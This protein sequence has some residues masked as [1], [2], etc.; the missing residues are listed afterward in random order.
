MDYK[1]YHRFAAKL[2]AYRQAFWKFNAQ[3]QPDKC[4]AILP[5][6]KLLESEEIKM[7]NDYINN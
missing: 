7:Y 4:A 2:R 6:L 1:E 5:R 3:M